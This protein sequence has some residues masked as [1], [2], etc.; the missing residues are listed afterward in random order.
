MHVGL[1]KMVLLPG[2]YLV[3]RLPGVASWGYYTLQLN[4][5]DELDCPRSRTLGER[6]RGNELCFG[7]NLESLLLRRKSPVPAPPK[8][9]RFSHDPW[10]FRVS[11]LLTAEWELKLLSGFRRQRVYVWFKTLTDTRGLLESTEFMGKEMRPLSS[12]CQLLFVLY[13]AFVLRTLHQKVT[14]LTCLCL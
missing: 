3:P 2:Q 6:R 1:V 13:M 7:K 10:T 11:E 12:L 14:F 4:C 9:G 8:H 5:L